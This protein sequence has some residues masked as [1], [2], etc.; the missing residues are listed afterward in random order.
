MAT[1]QKAQPW[2]DRYKLCEELGEGGNAKVFRV[3]EK[4]TG[5]EFA[6]KQLVH[7][8]TEKKTRFINEIQIVK[9]YVD[10]ID[11][12]LPIYEYSADEFW[13]VMPIA[14]PVMD[15]IS[16]S[17][18]TVD[19]IVDAVIQMADTLAKLHEEGV[20]HRDIKP[21]NVYY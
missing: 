3:Q 2:E 7:K 11:G 8:N 15:H 12:I 10:K 19:G 1:G 16:R 13:Y 6:L 21:S 17:K 4:S 14:T 5:K 18:L 20:S 9:E